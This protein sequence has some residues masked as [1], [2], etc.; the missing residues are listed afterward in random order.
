MFHLNIHIFYLFYEGISVNSGEGMS[1]TSMKSG[2]IK[3]G[4][5][6]YVIHI[7]GFLDPLLR[8][9]VRKNP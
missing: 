3:V 7:S 1:N 9:L 4:D 5:R 2:K 8:Y 6:P